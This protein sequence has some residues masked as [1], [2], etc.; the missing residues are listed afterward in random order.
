[1]KTKQDLSFC[2]TYKEVFEGYFIYKNS[3]GFNFEYREKLQLVKLNRFL[4]DYNCSKII[5]TKEMVD[6]YLDN[7]KELSSATQHT[8]ECRIRQVALYMRNLGYS[9]IYVLPENRIKVTTDF[10]PYIFSPHEMEKIFQTTDQL[11]NYPNVPR[12]RIFYQTI[13][14]LLYG[15]GMRISEVLNLKP[16]DV[17]LE[18]NL[19]IIYN[20]KGNVSRII[21]Y[22]KT[23]G[24]WLKKYNERES[25]PSDTYFFESIHGG[26][27]NRCAVKNFFENRILKGAGIDR[28]TDN[29]GPRLHDLRH[30]YACHALDKMIKAGMDPFCAL[31]YL[32]TYLGHKGLESTEKYLRLTYERFGEITEAG[33][34]IYEKGFGECYE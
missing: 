1:M 20:S 34:Y 11:P 27:C 32:S 13:I 3:L 23:V 17:D 7:I 18:N 10:V 6:R 31:P 33:H 29:T 22:D 4:N 30:T 2:G 16:E 14:R 21:P 28:K 19:L 25:K 26:K 5:L 8:Y 24:Y 12:C 15:T 9:D